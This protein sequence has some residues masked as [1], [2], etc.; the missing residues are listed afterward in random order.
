MA[1]PT[2]ADQCGIATGSADSLQ[3][4]VRRVATVLQLVLQRE[5]VFHRGAP[6]R[7][8]MNREIAALRGKLKRRAARLDDAYLKKSTGDL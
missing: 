5:R 1:N 3:H 4:I 8:S 7:G 2:D 6:E